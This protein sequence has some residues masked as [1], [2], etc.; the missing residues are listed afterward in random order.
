MFYCVKCQE[1][2]KWPKSMHKSQGRCESCGK[3]AECYDVPSSSLPDEVPVRKK[4]KPSNEVYLLISGETLQFEG[5]EQETLEYLAKNHDSG[6]AYRLYK[7]QE[8]EVEFV[9]KLKARR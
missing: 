6:M 8:M 9:A 5:D 1:K 3:V 7:A 2:N 4:V